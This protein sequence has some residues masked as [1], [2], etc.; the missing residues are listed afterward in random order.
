[1]TSY[2]IVILGNSTVGKSTMLHYARYN[3]FVDKIE[4]TIGCD[5]VA[6][7]VT[8]DQDKHVKLLFF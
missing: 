7:V 8:F 5:F 6:K 2:K 1:M 3:K 4:S